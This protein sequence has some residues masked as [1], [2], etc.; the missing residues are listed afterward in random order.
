MVRG[1]PNQ[2]P[3]GRT[4]SHEVEWQDPGD[5][6]GTV[7]S[8]RQEESTKH[9]VKLM[10]D[11]SECFD[12]WQEHKLNT[13]QAH[14]LAEEL[15]D[16]I[17]E[18]PAPSRR[19]LERDYQMTKEDRQYEHERWIALK[20]A[21]DAEYARSQA[22][23]WSIV[24]CG[25]YSAENSRGCSRICAP[26]LA[27]AVRDGTVPMEGPSPLMAKGD[28]IDFSSD[29]VGKE[30]S[31]NFTFSDSAAASQAKDARGGGAW[32]PASSARWKEAQ[33]RHLAGAVGERGGLL[34]SAAAAELKGRRRDHLASSSHDTLGP[35]DETKEV[36]H[37]DPELLK[38]QRDFSKAGRATQ[39]QREALGLTKL[40][41]L[42]LYSHWRQGTQGDCS[43]ECPG[44]L[45]V[46][47]RLKWE[48][49]NRLR[50]M[51]QADAQREYLR[52]ASSMGVQW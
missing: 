4:N 2:R 43:E 27:P 42:Q 14:R 5:S 6:Q 38:L 45:E 41:L 26:G 20:A 31:F 33:Q 19:I 37:G 3:V 50:G 21:F 12:K 9:Y 32:E 8:R 28:T 25:I 44:M 16:A 34:S 18:L 30:S 47:G 29:M 15:L 24:T 49:W 10:Q 35:L 17:R 13:T 48:A 46:V 11:L 36:G 39:E 51:S 40:Q 1:I 7:G 22:R 23:F 52:L